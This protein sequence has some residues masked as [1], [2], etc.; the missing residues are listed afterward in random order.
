[1]KVFNLVKK[2]IIAATTLSTIL[3]STSAFAI[4]F[5]TNNVYKAV[6]NSQTVVYLSGTASSKVAVDLGSVDKTQAR[7]AGACGETKISVP[8]SGSF[9]GLKVDGTTVDAS[10]LSV[11]TLPACVSGTFAEPRTTNFKTA[12]GQVVIVGK[13]PNA[14]VSITLPS[15]SAKSVSINA[16]GFGTIKSTSSTPLPASFKIGTNNYTVS[17]LPNAGSGPVCRTMNGISTGYVPAAWP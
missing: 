7:I 15:N 2:G 17:T 9:T 10:T 4:P 11:Q 16:C 5:G 8:T 3:A 6:E 12:S 1:M 14:A 13:T